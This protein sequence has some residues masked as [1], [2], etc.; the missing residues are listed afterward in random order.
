[1]FSGGRERVHWEC[2]GLKK[3]LNQQGFNNICEQLLQSAKY[4]FL[5]IKSASVIVLQSVGL[6]ETNSFHRFTNKSLSPFQEPLQKRN[7]LRD[8]K[9]ITRKSFKSDHFCQESGA[10][11][12]S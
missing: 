3:E 2:M 6:M 1:M 4:F 7:V 11:N 8:S 10:V 5:V 9:Q 12:Y